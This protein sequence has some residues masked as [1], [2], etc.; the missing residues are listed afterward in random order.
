MIKFP[1][2]LVMGSDQSEDSYARWLS[3]D[4]M[5]SV[6]RFT[7]DSDRHV[8]CEPYYCAYF[9]GG[10][11]ERIGKADTKAEIANIVNRHRLGN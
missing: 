1:F 11:S 7:Y 8:E 6:Q 10:M 2:K 5:Y 4:G 9:V 3:G